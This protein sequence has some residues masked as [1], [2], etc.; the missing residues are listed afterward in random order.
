M[1]VKDFQRLLRTYHGGQDDAWRAG[2]EGVSAVTADGYLCRVENVNNL[3]EDGVVF[4]L[5]FLA[6]Q[7]DVS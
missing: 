2:S 4:T 5:V 1:L 7:L 6:D 3:A